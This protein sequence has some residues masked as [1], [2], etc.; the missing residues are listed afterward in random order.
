MLRPTRRHR[1][2]PKRPPRPGRPAWTALAVAATLPLALALAP[3]AAQGVEAERFALSDVLPGATAIAFVPPGTLYVAKADAAYFCVYSILPD[4]LDA[5]AA[6]RT[7]EVPRPEGTCVD[8]RI[9]D[10]HQN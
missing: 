1:N 8:A 5:I 4:F 10:I 2:R 6:D 9:F 3:A 7:G